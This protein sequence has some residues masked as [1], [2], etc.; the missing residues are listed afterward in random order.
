MKDET[1]TGGI[2]AVFFT[3]TACET[4]FAK[5]CVL[6]FLDW[7]IVFSFAITLHV[8]KILYFSK[9]Q[10]KTTMKTA[11]NCGFGSIQFPKKPHIR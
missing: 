9:Y 3:K 11:R 10:A 7:F 8:N 6:T 1:K 2:W 4:F 5:Y